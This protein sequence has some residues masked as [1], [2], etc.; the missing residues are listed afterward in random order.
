MHAT[1]GDKSPRARYR[2][3]D[4]ETLISI[5]Q[6]TKDPWEEIA[7]RYPVS[8]KVHVQSSA[9]GLV[10]LEPRRERYYGSRAPHEIAHQK[11]TDP[12]EEGLKI[13][14]KVDAR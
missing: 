2:N 12:S 8:K 7:E 10:I 11:I 13:G 9:C 1:V 14:Q 3:I 6:L 5:K 4:S